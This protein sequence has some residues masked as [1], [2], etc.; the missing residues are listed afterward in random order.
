M[1]SITCKKIYTYCDVLLANKK[2]AL[3]VQK[4]DFKKNLMVICSIVPHVPNKRFAA[5]YR[6]H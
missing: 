5:L 3:A 1:K 4:R 2:E 6:M